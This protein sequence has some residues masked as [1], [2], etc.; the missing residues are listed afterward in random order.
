ME[1]EGSM[2]RRS[3]NSEE[4]IPTNVLDELADELFAQLD[5]EEG[6]RSAGRFN[7]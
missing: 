3:C 5:A 6:S 2:A 4:D 7:S 1:L